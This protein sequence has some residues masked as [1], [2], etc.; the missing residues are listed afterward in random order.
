MSTTG[1]APRERLADL[2]DAV[3]RRAGAQRGGAGGVDHR[4]VGERV[5]VRDAELD[6]VG[7][8]VG[9]GLADPQRGRHVG[10]A[11]H[12]VRHQ[13]GAAAAQR[14]RPAAMRSW[15]VCGDRRDAVAG[16]LAG[17]H[18]SCAMTSARS[19][20]PRPDRQTRSSVEPSPSS[21]SA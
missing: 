21:C 16:G 9:V 20:S 19:L 5:G 17:S 8:V 12:E 11:A 14:R 10:E 1:S 4:A 15:P 7:A 2:E 18:S 3:E 13:R 6:E